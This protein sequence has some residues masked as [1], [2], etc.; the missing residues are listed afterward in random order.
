MDRISTM[1]LNIGITPDLKGFEY[2]KEGVALIIAKK[3]PGIYL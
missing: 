1:L 2:I 3:K